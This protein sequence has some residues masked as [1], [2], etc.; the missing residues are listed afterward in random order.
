MNAIDLQ[1]IAETHEQPFLIIDPQFR[2][3]AANRAFQLA[4]R[5]SLQDVLGKHCFQV[6]H[7][8]PGPCFER[9]EQCSLTKV[10]ETG[11]PCSC[12]H[13]HT[14]RDEERRIHHVR[15][16]GYPLRLGADSFYLG[17]SMVEISV[18]DEECDPSDCMLGHSKPFLATL[19][20]MKVAAQS[21]APVLLQGETGTGKELAANFIHR[22]SPRSRRPFLTL[23]CP[24]LT[25]TLVES[26]LFGHERGAFTG[27]VG[28]RQ[29]LFKLANGG[30]LFLD[31]IGEMPQR[32]QTKLLRVLETGQ[33]RRVGGN[34]IMESDVRII[35]A[36]NRD[37]QDELERGSFRE[38]LYYRL[39]CFSIQLPSLRERREDIPELALFWLKQTRHPGQRCLR[40]TP[41]ALALLKGYDFP[42]NVRELRNIL[43][44]AAAHATGTSIDDSLVRAIM[45]RRTEGRRNGDLSIGGRSPREPDVE[46]AGPSHQEIERDQLSRML[47][48]HKGNRAAVAK[49]LGV[50]ERTVY[51][52]LKRYDL[53]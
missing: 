11:E 33:F 14:S 36:T 43:Q 47:R 37:L 12:L 23:D 51:R 28:D 6:S 45:G 7:G 3:V 49:A 8:V 5:I 18:R 44:A 17:E 35:C 41:E 32:L 21:D 15:V 16:K 2:V 53:K 20:A 50:T 24:A 22:Q 19:E 48:K 46:P 31:E 10:L 26:E 38:D 52:K 39:A 4:Y 40:L 34:R 1:S 25:E 27:S 9:G 42:G 13:V 29:G 30:T